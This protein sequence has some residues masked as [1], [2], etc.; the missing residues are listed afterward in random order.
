MPCAFALLAS[1]FLVACKKH[2]IPGINKDIR[3]S[4]TKQ[5][6]SVLTDKD[7]KTL[8]FFSI[9]A[10]G[11]SGC[12]GGCIAKWPVFYKDNPSLD[13]GLKASDFGSITRSD[14]AKQTT[15]KGWPLYYYSDDVKAGDIA[16]DGFGGVWFVGKPDYSV[17]FVKT[18]LVGLD[19]KNY[20]EDHK[21]GTGATLFL[22]DDW[23]NTLYAFSPDKFKKNNFTK[24]DFS[25]N[26]VWPIFEQTTVHY[27][28]STLSQSLLD[29]TNVFGKSQLTFK[30]WPL[31]H[32]GKDS[33][34]RGNT[35]GVSF[36]VPGIWPVVN[37][38]TATAPL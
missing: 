33:M 20:T 14:G 30:G 28:P 38:S 10:N 8:Y 15:Y 9:D 2:D 17:M 4:L 23:G 18:Q 31:Y 13:N 29:T 27:V 34:M 1:V 16:G 37:N 11:Q 26:A 12:T 19:G 5:F 35:R 36:P 3:L 21:E 25:N 32:F 22:T 7:G 6:G 24:P